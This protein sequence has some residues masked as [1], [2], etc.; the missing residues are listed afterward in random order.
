M[1]RGLLERLLRRRAQRR[2]RMAWVAAWPAA[3]R[4]GISA[5]RALGHSRQGPADFHLDNGGFR[6][7]RTFRRLI[8]ARLR[9]TRFLKRRIAYRRTWTWCAGANRYSSPTAARRWRVLWPG[10]HGMGQC[11][12]IDVEPSAAVRSS[13]QRLLAK[14]DL[15]SGDALQLTPRCADRR[16]K[17]IPS[18]SFVW[19]AGSAEA[20][21]ARVSPFCRNHRLEQG[22]SQ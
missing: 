9:P 6:L 19:T 20:R 4:R 18:S 8:I 17:V 15:T 22:K 5:Q 21:N 13:A 3:R 12:W 16:G 7:A 11:T 1:D 2:Q 14:H 10:H